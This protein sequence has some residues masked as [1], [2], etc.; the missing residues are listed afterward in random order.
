MIVWPPVWPPG[1]PPWKNTEVAALSN[2]SHP[3]FQELH[4]KEN[5]MNAAARW[6]GRHQAPSHTSYE[7]LGKG[8]DPLGRPGKG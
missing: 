4:P 5:W 3:L 6:A 2:H 7:G 1:G 8:P